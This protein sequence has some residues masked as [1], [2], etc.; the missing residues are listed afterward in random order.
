MPANTIAPLTIQV[1]TIVKS[2][3]SFGFNFSG[4]PGA[5]VTVQRS[6]DLIDWDDVATLV[7]GEEPQAF[8]DELVGSDTR[9]FYRLRGGE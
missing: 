4:T 7:V 5:P 1:P 8:S 9:W 2:A 6:D 3:E